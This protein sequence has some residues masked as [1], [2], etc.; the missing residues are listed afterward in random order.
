MPKLKYP[1]NLKVQ[2]ITRLFPGESTYGR[3]KP[4]RHATARRAPLESASFPTA[5]RAGQT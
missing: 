3:L 5:R 2:A 1:T 4:V